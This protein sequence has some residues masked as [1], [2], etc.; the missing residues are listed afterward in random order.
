[1]LRSALLCSS[2][3]L[4]PGHQLATKYTAESKLAVDTRFE[5]VLETTEFTMERDGEPVEG[6][7]FGGGGTTIKRHS[8]WTDHVVA[9]ADGQPTKLRRSFDDLEQTTST[10]MGET[11]REVESDAPLE[12]VTLELSIGEDG[13][14]SSEV[15]DGTAP[16]DSALLD[17]HA[18]ALQLDALLPSEAVEDNASWDLDKDAIRTTLGVGLTEKLFVR[19]QDA[20]AEAGAERG[21]GGRGGRGGG[22]A[23][24]SA[25][26]FELAEWTGKAV[27]KGEEDVD[28]VACWVIELE[29]KGDGELPAAPMGGGGRRGGG[30]F[31]LPSEARAIENPF[32]IELEG[33]LK[34]SKAD[35]RPVALA[36]EGKAR[37]ESNMER[38]MQE[39]TMRVHTVQEGK[40]ELAIS[41]AAAAE[42]KPAAK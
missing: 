24:R 38:T 7:N 9:T 1:M 16:G 29:I 36:L 33:T 22:G 8:A 14:V 15:V 27:L 2:L 10:K 30:A 13:K 17:G 12:G 42:A 39:S 3:F 35:Q 21:G 20:A 40:I 28:G 25:R 37:V 31:A 6:R 26:L 41:I 5:M 23:G 11:E 4:L 18:L 34:F 32:E 19:A